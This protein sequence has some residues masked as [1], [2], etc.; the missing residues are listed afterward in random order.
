MNS[1][2]HGWFHDS[3]DLTKSRF[4]NKRAAEASTREPQTT[5]RAQVS[6]QV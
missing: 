1:L 4:S 5:T 3:D 6:T 2:S